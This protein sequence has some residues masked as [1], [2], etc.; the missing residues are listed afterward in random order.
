MT[1]PIPNQYSKKGASLSSEWIASFRYRPTAS[2]V[3]T[4]QTLQSAP[5]PLRYTRR[6]S[7]PFTGRPSRDSP[8]APLWFCDAATTAS[9]LQRRHDGSGF[10]TPPRR[11]ADPLAE[12]VPGWLRLPCDVANVM[13]LN[14]FDATRSRLP[15]TTHLANTTIQYSVNTTRIWPECNQNRAS[16]QSKYGP[17]TA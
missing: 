13:Q 10:A 1:Q 11:L 12:A 3:A 6:S 5:A 8:L 4:W 9:V 16:I 17:N 14:I 15:H 2:S 7:I